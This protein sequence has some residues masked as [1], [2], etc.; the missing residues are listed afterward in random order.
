MV[1]W[2]LIV[3]FLLHG[4]ALLFIVLLYM[5]F[6][7]LKE[8][9]QT[10]SVMMKEMEEVIS[11]HLMEMKEQN[12]EF[13]RKFEQ[14]KQDKGNA[15]KKQSP[16]PDIPVFDKLSIP[17]EQDFLEMMETETADNGNIPKPALKQEE[18]E[19]LSK[20]DGRK[21]MTPEQ[22]KK[23]AISLQKKGLTI[24][25][26]AKHLHRGKTEIELLLIFNKNL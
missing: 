10:Q 26:I 24:E 2:I 20:W 7:R 5:R 3:S 21:D 23:M 11:A 18:Q 12:D 4:L 8:I 9:E 13:I 1:A 22:I 16:P 15:R 19:V 6:V 25:E 17:S 14:M